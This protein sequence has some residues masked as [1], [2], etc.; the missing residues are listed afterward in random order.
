MK[1]P[2]FQTAVVHPKVP[3]VRPTHSKAT[4]IYQSSVFTF[5]SL[6]DLES[7]YTGEH[8]YLYS[9]M[10]NP[11]TDELGS[12]V[13]EW[14]GADGGIATSSGMSAILAS[15]FAVC[16]TGDHIV[17]ARDVYGGSYHLLA[18]ECA[19]FGISVSFV[20]GGIASFAAAIRPN[21]KVL[22]SES[23]TNPVLRVENLAQL[24]SLAKERGLVTIIDNTFP[25]PYLVRPLQV[26]IDISVHSATKYI[27][28]HSDVTAGVAV[29]NEPYLSKIRQKVVNLGANIS[30]FEAWLAVRGSKT[31][32]LRMKQQCAVANAVA[33]ELST[34]NEVQTVYYPSNLSPQ[35]N[36]AIVT[37]TLQEG[38]NMPVFF[39]ALDWI[40]IVPS[41]AGVETTVSYPTVASHR[42]LPIAEQKKLGIT[43]TMVR[44][45][46]GI[47]EQKDVV[48]Q[49]KYAIVKSFEK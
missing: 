20:E 47:E 26:G 19:Q 4:P 33:R 41:L 24:A 36:G 17:A 42:A 16:K 30:P 21:T 22:Y 6:A 40:H 11:N 23:V 49:L 9:R 12:R 1:N 35:G 34:M 18:E 32:A 39:E 45:S 48:D 25:T 2:S 29:A 43:E 44:I 8:S 38:A 14:E 13:A 27:G 28:G 7:Y 46:C 5:H 31:L 3:V 15:L 37:I 10:G